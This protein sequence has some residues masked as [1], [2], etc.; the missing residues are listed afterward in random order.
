MELYITPTS[1]YARMVRIVIHEKG[2]ASD[3]EIIEAKTRSEGSSYYAVNPSGRVPYL[4]TEEGR[5]L[6]DSALI[7]RY[8]DHLDAEPRLEGGG[9]AADRW[10]A[11]RLEASA[12]S[13]LDGIAVWA[14]EL[15]RPENERSPTLIAHEAA[16]SRRLAAWWES[17]IAH[18]WM[19]GAFNYAQLTLIVTLELEA[20][21]EA[22]SWR[23]AHPALAAWADRVGARPS[24]AS[25]RSST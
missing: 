20:R 10:E 16:R 7:C 13:M 22:L 3:V 24:I 12:R 5:A 1:P 23:P 2:L 11:E 4:V 8:L 14:R 18:P 17:E 21:L 6:E 19:G 25:T 15:R 9:D